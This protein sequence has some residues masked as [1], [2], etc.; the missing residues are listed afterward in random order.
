[1]TRTTVA[2]PA[3]EDVLD[4]LR[5]VPEIASYIRRSERATYHGLQAGQIPAFKEGNIWITTK[6]R[7]RLYYNG[8]LTLPPKIA[9][10]PSKPEATK[11]V[12]RR[13]RIRS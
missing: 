9:V 3:S 6:T 1:M 5:G 11:P 8:E 12:V 2:A 7:L 13:R 4:V 10:E